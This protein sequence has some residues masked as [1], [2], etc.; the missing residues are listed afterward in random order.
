[1]K[2]A[3]GMAALCANIFSLPLQSAANATPRASSTPRR[4]VTSNSR[5]STTTTI[6]LATPVAQLISPACGSSPNA[7]LHSGSANFGLAR[8]TNAPSTSTLSTNGSITRPKSVTTPHL[9]AR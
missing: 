8:Y 2:S 3:V 9:R 1:M 4:L 5:A 6:Q 7:R